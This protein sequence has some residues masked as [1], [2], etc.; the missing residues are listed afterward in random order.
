MKTRSLLIMMGVVSLL[1]GCGGGGGDDDGLP[2]DGEE[3]TLGSYAYSISAVQGNPFTVTLGSAIIGVDPG[4]TITGTVELGTSGDVGFTDG[5]NTFLT[6]RNI[7][8]GSTFSVDTE[9][10]SSTA[11]GAFD[12]TVAEELAF[13]AENPPT[14]GALDVVTTTPGP[15]N[16]HI[17]V[18]S[19]GVVLS[20]N[21]QVPVPLSWSEFDDLLDGA[22]PDWQ[23]RAALAYQALKF[24]YIR[25]FD[26]VKVLDLIDD[27]LPSNNPKTV[28]CDAFTGTAPDGVA[29]PGMAV[30]TWLGSGDLQ[31]GDDF[32]LQLTDCWLDESF[33][34]RDEVLNG[35]IHLTGYTEVIDDLN[36]ITRI[37]F[38]PFQSSPGGVI[39]D[40]YE[41]QGLVENPSGSGNYVFDSGDAPVLNG[42]FS[43]VFFEQP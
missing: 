20:L 16:I 39:F 4:N 26:I 23:K 7:A 37:G 34:D 38:E 15:E 19:N 14:A 32:D 8:T 40:N 31:P 10:G 6:R 2:D 25:A 41:I 27:T 22:A 36:R 30:L 28:Q 3:V 5:D 35:T 29:N 42:G 17:A 13:F 24:L 33:K 12:V 18:V 21:S 11:L 43:V 1:F 9:L